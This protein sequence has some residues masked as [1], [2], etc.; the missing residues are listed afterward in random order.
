MSWK[1]ERYLLPAKKKD[2]TLQRGRDMLDGL[3]TSN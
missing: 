2:G 1:M 3:F